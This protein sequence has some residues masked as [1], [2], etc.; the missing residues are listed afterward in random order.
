MAPIPL[1]LTV[2]RESG[3]RG[4]VGGMGEQKAVRVSGALVISLLAF[5]V[6][7]YAAIVANQARDTADRNERYTD[8]MVNSIM[9]IAGDAKS[10]AFDALGKVGY[11]RYQIEHPK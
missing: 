1:T 6:A 8:K 10:I 3:D 5:G 11:L 9:G 2:N 4:T 7:V